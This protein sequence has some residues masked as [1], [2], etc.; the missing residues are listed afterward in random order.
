MHVH[1]CTHPRRRQVWNNGITYSFANTPLNA[2][3][4]PLAT[5]KN[6]QCFLHEEVS[7]MSILS[8]VGGVLL[9][10]R[11]ESWRC[12]V[13]GEVGGLVRRLRVSMRT[14]VTTYECYV[15]GGWWWVLLMWLNKEA[16]FQKKEWMSTGIGE[17]QFPK[18]HLSL[19]RQW[20]LKHWHCPR[21]DKT[22]ELECFSELASAVVIGEQWT[23]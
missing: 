9:S 15:G 10:A 23:Q 2:A 18:T 5:A 7:S 20:Q 11:E 13:A 1:I 17:W 8:A 4:A 14:Y 16:L 6:I 21:S 19:S 3:Q 12:W 22:V